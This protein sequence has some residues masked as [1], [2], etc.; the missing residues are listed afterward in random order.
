MFNDLQK[1]IEKT[2]NERKLDIKPT[3]P[4]A[5]A[6][7]G[8]IMS[9]PGTEKVVLST[10]VLD[11]MTCAAIG[12]GPRAKER[13]CIVYKDSTVKYNGQ[14]VDSN[15]HPV[16]IVP[17]VVFE[18]IVALLHNLNKQVQNLKRDLDRATT[19]KEAYKMTIETLRKNGVID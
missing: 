6:M 13:Y 17:K 18:N 12:T 9:V 3:V 7:H 8:T 1:E 4:D 5:P 10:N 11:F 2:L 15:G 14:F 19:D 16:S